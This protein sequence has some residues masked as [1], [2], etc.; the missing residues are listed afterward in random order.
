M[1]RLERM[2]S[3]FDSPGSGHVSSMA[4]KRKARA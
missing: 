1:V 3:V 4:Q 2:A